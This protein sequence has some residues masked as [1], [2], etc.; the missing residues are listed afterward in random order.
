M[1]RLILL[2]LALGLGLWAIRTFRTLLV[3]APARKASHAAY[4]CQSAP[5]LTDIRKQLQPTGFPRVAG[6]YHGLSVDLQALPDTLTFRKLP[7]LW[8]MVTLTEPQPLTGETHIMA[9]ASGLETFSTYAQMPVEVTLPISFPPDCTL[10]CTDADALPAPEVMAKLASLFTNPTVKEA[11]LSPKGLRLVV[12][13]EEADRTPYLI[14]R[15]AELGRTPLPADRLK[16]LLN[17]LTD[18]HTAQ[19]P[20]VP[21]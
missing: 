3:A 15:D 21:A 7:A 6:R 5:V 1:S 4:F 18:L 16:L 17:A 9:R 8:V 10:R 20:K 12:L 14:F 19:T 13:A 2:L 11:V